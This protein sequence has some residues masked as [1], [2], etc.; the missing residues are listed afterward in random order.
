MKNVLPKLW[1]E[2]AASIAVETALALPLALLVGVGG[3]EVASYV[4]AHSRVENLSYVVA[5]MATS[6][7]GDLTEKRIADTFKAVDKI[8]KL[9]DFK[10]KGKLI[11]TAYEVTSTTAATKLWQ[12]CTGGAKHSSRYKGANIEAPTNA[13]FMKGDTGVAVEVYYPPNFGI[14]FL[15]NGDSDHLAIDRPPDFL[16]S[17]DVPFTAA[18]KNADNFSLSNNG[19]C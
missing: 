2:K 6:Y 7:G 3:F 10:A 4:Q 11:I 8:S 18:V 16:S 13:V 15:S 14:N 5:N 9:P 12:R 17:R 19:E 1:H